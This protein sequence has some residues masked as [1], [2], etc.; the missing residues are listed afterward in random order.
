MLIWL[1]RLNPITKNVSA[2]TPIMCILDL[3]LKKSNTNAI[4]VVI[5]PAKKKKYN[6]GNRSIVMLCLIK[7]TVNAICK[8]SGILR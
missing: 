5:N 4:N 1:C 3:I 2:L 7:T 6:S 8:S